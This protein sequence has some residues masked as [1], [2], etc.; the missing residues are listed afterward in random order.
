MALDA[1]LRTLEGIDETTAALYKPREGGG[2]LLDVNDSASD[3]GSNFGL[4]DFGGLKSA[5]TSERGI[6]AQY[7]S[8]LAQ[9]NGIDIT[10]ANEALE[11][12]SKYSGKTNDDLD[13]KIAELR[14]GYDDKLSVANAATQEAINA[15]NNFQL[16]HTVDAAIMSRDDLNPTMTKWLRGEILSNM[17]ISEA[18]VFVADANGNPRMSAQASNTGNMGVGE[19]IDSMASNVSEFGGFFKATGAGGGAGNQ[20]NS[21]SNTGTSAKPTSKAE[22]RALTQDKQVELYHSDPSYYKGLISQ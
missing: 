15:K 8:D 11:F 1:L 22:Y 10:A 5:L 6:S 14:T 18:G 19:L 4:G 16:G 3:D 17:G 21:N 2:F 20:Q 9:Y 12:K 7:K 13:A